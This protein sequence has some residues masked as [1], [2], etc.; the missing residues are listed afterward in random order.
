MAQ[1]TTAFA[2]ANGQ[3]S[4]IF[5]YLHD[6][7]AAASPHLTNRGSR[8]IIVVIGFHA[9]VILLLAVVALPVGHGARSCGDVDA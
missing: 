1:S 3:L 8:V 2:Y 6:F 4:L 5:K 7:I 9:D